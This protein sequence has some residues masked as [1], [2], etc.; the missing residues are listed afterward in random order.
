MDTHT[1][2][3]SHSS[4]PQSK[5]R[6]LARDGFR[7]PEFIR[8]LITRWWF[9]VLIVIAI[10]L[11]IVHLFLAVWVRDYVNRKLSEVPGYRA[12]VAAVTLHL[13]RGAYAIHGLD[14]RKTNG[15][16]P[17]PFFST[18][19]VDLSVQWRALIFE[20]AFV[21]NIEIHR[22]EINLVNGSTEATRQAPVDEPWAQKIK[23]LFPLKINRFAVHDGEI[24]YRDFSHTPQVKLWIDD[25]QMVATNLTNSK[26]LS[27]NLVADIRIQGRPLSAGDVRSQI[28]LDPYAP[29]PT[30]AFNLELRE[31][32]LVKLNDFAKAYGHFTFDAGTLKVAMEANASKGA[33][34]GYIE[35]VFDHMSIFNPAKE[36][37]PLTAVWEAILEGVTR[38]VRNHPKDRFGTKVPFSGTFDHPNPEILT[39]VFNAFRNAF[40]KAFA[41]E[42]PPGHEPPRVEPAKKQ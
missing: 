11:V 10:S 20:R 38:I 19:L 8:R 16:V 13:W 27:K 25:V 21:G 23:Q 40:V 30:F 28:S 41:G 15:K 39:T 2:S 14:I 18:P 29:K 4:A 5:K 36:N 42:L 24:R 3:E 22:P 34:K 32:P 26:K 12:H 9:W 17:V 35:P 6:G 31:M 7:S 1:T 37:N 33:Y